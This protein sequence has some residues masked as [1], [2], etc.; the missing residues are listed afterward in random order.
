MSAD[1]F[2]SEVVVLADGSSEEEPVTFGSE[3]AGLLDLTER[4]VHVDAEPVD[5]VE[6]IIDE[7]AL[8]VGCHGQR[9]R[10]PLEWQA[11][12]R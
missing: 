4:K 7:L 11:L 8:L 6:S 9:A 12:R 1:V 5:L 10:E 3:L 2:A